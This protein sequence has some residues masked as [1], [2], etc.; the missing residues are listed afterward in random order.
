MNLIANLSSKI[1]NNQ[2]KY[3]HFLLYP[4]SKL[5]IEVVKLLFK[6]NFIRG[7]YIEKQNNKPYV[8]LLVKYGAHKH[9]LKKISVISKINSNKKF[10]QIVKYNNGLGFY[11]LSTS[12]GFITNYQAAKLKLGG[13]LILKIY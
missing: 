12:K 7:F 8:Y 13:K 1:N 9:V 11:I 3:T 4:A 10:Y 6:Q 2:Q 5:L